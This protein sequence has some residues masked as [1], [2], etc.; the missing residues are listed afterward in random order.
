LR[1]LF[2]PARV[3]APD[4][5]RLAP[6]ADRLAPGAAEFAH[7]ATELEVRVDPT[8]TR[9]PHASN[10]MSH[11]RS[12][13]ALIA[14]AVA[15]A[16]AAAQLD[17]PAEPAREHA[18][19]K[20]VDL[21]T[22]PRG[23]LA[24]PVSGR[25]IYANRPQ[26]GTGALSLP[27]QRSKPAAP[28][29]PRTPPGAPA[30]SVA[31]P[32]GSAPTEPAQPSTAEEAASASAVRF[33]L[34]EVAKVREVTSSMVEHGSQ[35]LVRLGPAGR[36]GALQALTSEH[37]AS[38]LL[39]ANA[40]LSFSDDASHEAVLERVRG[41][42][43]TAVCTPLV[44]LV[45][46]RD[47]VRASPAWLAELLAHK[48]SAVRS[49]AQR[50][51]ALA[52]PELPAA[53]LLTPLR[54]K[55]IDARLRGVALLAQL[56]DP[57]A[58]GLLL[59]RL[60][61]PSA[62]VGSRAANALAL[63][64]DERIPGELLRRALD[65]PWI[66]RE[67]ALALVALVEREDLL[68]E[69]HLTDVHRARLLDGMTSSEP[70]VAGA[71][72]AA[73]AGIGYRGVAGQETRWFDLDVPHRLV[74]IVAAQDFAP[75]LSTLVPSAV[76]RLAL[77][78]GVDFGA[79]GPRWMDWWSS[80][81][82]TFKGARA[83]L[84]YGPDSAL[85]LELAVRSN[86]GGTEN[87][88]LLGPAWAAQGEPSRA[89][90][91]ERLFLSEAQA[92]GAFEELRRLGLLGLE[93][94]PG[95]RGSPSGAGRTLVVGVD[96]RS[97]S[98]RFAQTRA[99]AWFDSAVELARSLRERNT[100]Q[101]LRDPRGAVGA[102]EFW[103]IE[104]PWWD[105]QTD[106]AAKARR[107]FDMTLARAASAPV[108]QREGLV[109]RLE[110]CA[111]DLPA[112]TRADAHNLL[113]LLAG[114]PHVST[115]V[116]M[117]LR[118]CLAGFSV[119][120]VLPQIDAAAVVERLLETF[121]PDAAAQIART[122]ESAAP[123]FATQA[124]Q[125]ERPFVRAVAASVLA[126]R[127]GSDDAP[128]LLAMLDDSSVEVQAAVLLALADRKLEAARDSILL[129]A[130]MAEGEVRLAALRACGRLG[131]EG[132]L[133]ALIAGLSDTSDSRVPVAA[134]QGL[135]DLREPGAAPIL[136]SLLSRGPADASYTYARAGLIALGESG[137]DEL[138][139]V[140]RASS[141]RAR[142][143]A[144]LILSQQL[145]PQA[146]SVLMTLLT[147]DPT[148][149]RAAEELA[150]LT[151][152]DYRTEA[153]PSA[154]WWAWWDYVVRDDAQAWLCGALSRLQLGA[155][156]PEEVRRGDPAALKLLFELCARDEAHLVER[157]RREL[158]RLAGRDLGRMPPR[159]RERDLWLATLR[160]SISRAK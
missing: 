144:A 79:D 145:I 109:D 87:F 128:R 92:R 84:E 133:S 6:I 25:R 98:F 139:R 150:I 137:V 40:L 81:A 156:T 151:C 54:S 136:V 62:S 138:L 91:G 112:L 56:S 141:H 125:D 61:D 93:R 106:E 21:R 52:G 158:S 29:T 124:T 39:G 8:P 96:G 113:D 14:L 69:T 33:V 129:R 101:S 63:R 82:S 77:I 57:A 32:A 143:E 38:V 30:P 43:P 114:E 45:V 3:L 47:P 148:D 126:K 127:G 89:V 71:C 5:D 154:S 122:M 72:A 86:L 26:S 123:D 9:R 83:R 35:T 37:A 27:D 147:E 99:E 65:A 102:E 55:D 105:E 53:N 16:P 80:N 42:L 11:L 44:D 12:L 142:R 149:T 49:A 4:P 59:E 28:R 95:V 131:G 157:A 155:P 74:R 73:L 103:R 7:R 76:R 146:A 75:D 70:F 110:T 46:A 23:N 135:A 130:R 85:R 115:R 132:A 94:L 10:L 2:A 107:L 121:G 20:A 160:E 152:V 116:D 34:E 111:K 159:G 15:A 100:W 31:A 24:E 134:A 50:H 1:I 22:P 60:V 13:L 41:K 48:Q 67:Q 19:D 78:T 120:G 58:T 68:F 153:S 104:A 64:D 51:L 17:L 36:V 90:L 118:L 119:E 140:V 108:G 117:L 18:R 66:L 97:K 88:T